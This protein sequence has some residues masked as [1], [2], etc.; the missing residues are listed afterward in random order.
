[1]TQS[2]Q[3]AIKV[4]SHIVVAI[5]PIPEFDEGVGESLIVSDGE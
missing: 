1:M 4:H 3:V 5:S 2:R